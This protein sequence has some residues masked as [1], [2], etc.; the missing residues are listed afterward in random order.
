MGGSGNL[1]GQILT[2]PV[3]IMHT[4]LPK[5]GWTQ[6]IDQT[7][8]GTPNFLPVLSISQGKLTV[9]ICLQVPQILKSD[10]Q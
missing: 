5:T 8:I 6:V 10:L 4:F 3:F 2:S 9:C 1:G 7:L